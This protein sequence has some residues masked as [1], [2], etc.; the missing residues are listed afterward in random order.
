MRWGAHA[1]H[2]HHPP[3]SRLTWATHEQSCWQVVEEDT[4]DPE[5]HSVEQQVQF[6]TAIQLKSNSYCLKF[7][8]L[9]R[10]LCVLGPLKFQLMMIT[11]TKILTV[12]MMKVKSKYLAMSGNTREVG[13]RIFDTSSRNTTSDSKMLIPN[14]TYDK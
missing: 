5:G 6:S 2:F 1:G 3:Q 8:I 11:V 14:V 7:S 12:F 9:K 13:G 4:S 10:Y